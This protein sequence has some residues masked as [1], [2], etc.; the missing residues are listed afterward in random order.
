MPWQDYAADVE[1]QFNP[2]ANPQID[3]KGE[4]ERRAQ[5][6]AAARG[7]MTGRYDVRYGPGPRQLLDIFAA[8][9][10]HAPI[11]VYIHGGYWRM[12]DKNS[13]SLIAEP[14]V[15]A[16]IPTVLPTYDLCPQVTLDQLVAQVLDAIAWIH[17]NAASIGGDGNRMYLSG[18]SA[19]AHLCA[20]ALAHDWMQRGLPADFIRGATLLTGVYDIEPTLHTSINEL[21]RLTPDMVRRNSPLFNPPRRPLP[22][23]FEVGGDE[24]PGWQA[25]TLAFAKVCADAGCTTEVFVLPGET[26]FSIARSLADPQHPLTQKMIAQM[27]G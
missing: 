25:Q 4:F 15:Q 7:R 1:R 24:P 23:L 6:S 22:L 14:F 16:G 19:G 26:H 21:V 18:S 8:G 3:V 10:G 11:H 9:D 12:G 20:M 13:Q 5:L 27:R 17:R 2:Q